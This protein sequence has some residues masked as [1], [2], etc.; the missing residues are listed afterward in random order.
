MLTV[1]WYSLSLLF[2]VSFVCGRGE[3]T[4]LSARSFCNSVAV[5]A[6]AAPCKQSF[7]TKRSHNTILFDSESLRWRS[8]RLPLRFP[9]NF[10]QCARWRWQNRNKYIPYISWIFGVVRVCQA[11]LVSMLLFQ[12]LTHPHNG[13]HIAIFI[14]IV[15]EICLPQQDIQLSHVR[16]YFSW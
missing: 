9:F 11:H 8:F 6:L 13:K 12:L 15:Y 3:S 14:Y 5:S 4:A 16:D 2:A 1:G 7:S 10:L